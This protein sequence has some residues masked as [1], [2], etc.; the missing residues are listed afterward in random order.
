MGC[1]W[2]KRRIEGDKLAGETQQRQRQRKKITMY[3]I[4]RG[5]RRDPRL[6]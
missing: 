2:D 6:S 5:D 1:S 4:E 3:E